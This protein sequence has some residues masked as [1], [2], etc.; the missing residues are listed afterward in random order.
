MATGRALQFTRFSFSMTTSS[1]AN[2]N[3]LRISNSQPRSNQTR[4]SAADSPTMRQGIG[5][6]HW[7]IATSITTG[8]PIQEEY[9][10]E[11]S[12]VS[13]AIIFVLRSI[14]IDSTGCTYTFSAVANRNLFKLGQLPFG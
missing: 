11:K 7:R 12:F 4:T 10:G 3:S 8:L 5:K 6:R 9:T 2:I 14:V 13:S 1:T